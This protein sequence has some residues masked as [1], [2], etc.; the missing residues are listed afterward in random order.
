MSLR[1]GFLAK[2]EVTPWLALVCMFQPG[3]IAIRHIPRVSLKCFTSSAHVGLEK[4]KLT[5]LSVPC[6]FLWV[7]L[8]SSEKQGM[9]LLSSWVRG[10]QE[11]VHMVD[12]NRTAAAFLHTYHYRL[13]GLNPDANLDIQ[14]GRS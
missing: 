7:Q 14:N 5:F 3:G 4:P 9:G 2:R 6:F 8:Y 13:L 1:R 11:E 12:A 10:E